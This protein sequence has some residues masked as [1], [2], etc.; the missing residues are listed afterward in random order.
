MR[1]QRA[2]LAVDDSTDT[3][4]TFFDSTGN[5]TGGYG[6]NA[7]TAFTLYDGS[8][9]IVQWAMA[10]QA[11]GPQV[12]DAGAWIYPGSRYANSHGSATINNTYADIIFTWMGSTYWAYLDGVPVATGTFAAALPALGQLTHVV[13][14]GYLGGALA[15]TVT[16]LI[17]QSTGSFVLALVVG[18]GIGV[19]S[20]ASYLFVVKDPITADDLG[21]SAI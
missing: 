1:L 5:A 11:S 16:G 8:N 4:S 10:A 20:A 13:I 14:G 15:P 7:A 21:V 9:N 18:A 12:L 19:L 6:A 2:A 17:V 3:G